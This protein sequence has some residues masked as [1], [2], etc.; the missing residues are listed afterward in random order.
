MY[1]R[2]SYNNQYVGIDAAPSVGVK[3]SNGCQD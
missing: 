2:S 3:A 1:P